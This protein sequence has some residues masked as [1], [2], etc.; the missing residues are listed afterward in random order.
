MY[1]ST[2]LFDL[3]L[4]S[5][6]HVLLSQ[7]CSPLCLFILSTFYDHI[8][9]NVVVVVNSM[10]YRFKKYLFMSLW[11]KFCRSLYQWE[12]TYSVVIEWEA[13]LPEIAK[14]IKR[15]RTPRTNKQELKD[16]IH[17]EA[18]R[19]KMSSFNVVLPFVSFRTT[20]LQYYQPLYL[21]RFLPA[22]DNNTL[23]WNYVKPDIWS[24]QTLQTVFVFEKKGFANCKWSRFTV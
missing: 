19:R 20:L 10:F 1:N 5:T 16:H 4:N 23:M 6:T 11:A 14:I 12:F 3:P 21:Q 2:D 15:Q 9:M 8:I 22:N 13:I 17:T 18:I 7:L 24:F